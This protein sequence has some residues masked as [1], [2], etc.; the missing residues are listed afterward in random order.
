MQFS[1]SVS[2]SKY[3]L[4][5]K[6]SHLTSNCCICVILL[7][8]SLNNVLVWY[9]TP[10]IYN[11]VVDQITISIPISNSTMQ[12]KQILQIVNYLENKTRRYIMLK[13]NIIVLLIY[14]NVHMVIVSR[15][16]IFDVK[17]TRFVMQ[18][19]QSKSF[20]CTKEIYDYLNGTVYMRLWCDINL[21]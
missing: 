4:T 11:F 1:V 10:K 3:T 9:L 6:C 15:N 8:I 14:F 12:F 21:I 5:D 20:G 13:W 2:V 19:I 18:V 7:S 17:S 16:L